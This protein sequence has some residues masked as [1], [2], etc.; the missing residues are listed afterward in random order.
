M[1]DFIHLI[2]YLLD[3]VEL[4]D[5]KEILVQAWQIWNQRNWVVHGGKLHDLGWLI[6]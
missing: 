5:M 1:A 2:D 6:N 4:H 3:W